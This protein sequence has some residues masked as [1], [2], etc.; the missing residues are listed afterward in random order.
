MGHKT[1]AKDELKCALS[2][3]THAQKLL[4]HY[5]LQGPQL[6]DSKIRK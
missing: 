6:M 2:D 4:K 5:M 1:N 3:I